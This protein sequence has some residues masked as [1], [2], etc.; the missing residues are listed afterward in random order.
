MSPSAATPSQAHQPVLLKETLAAIV[1]RNGGKYVD[2]TLG[3]GGHTEA[4]LEASAPQGRVLGMDVDPQALEISSER[5]QK[6]DGR[7][8]IVHNSYTQLLE[9][10]HRIGWREVDGVLFDLGVS[11][12]QLDTSRRGFSFKTDAPL[13]MRFD[14]ANSISAD[15]LVNTLPEEDL[16]NLIWKFGEERESRRIAR[17]VC[18]ARPVHTTG[19]LA[20]IIHRAIRKSSGRIDPATR[21]FQA[22]RIAVNSELQAIE[23]ALPCAVEA[24]KPGGRLAVISFHSLEDRLVKQFMRRE[25]SDCI[26]PPGTPVCTCGHKA[27]L[28]ELSRKGITVSAFETDQNPRARSA[29]LRTAEKVGLA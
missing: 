16:A 9:E 4:M 14:P 20:E 7:V 19:Q 3:A 29:R 10:M 23:E 13:D 1:P 6:F 25:S 26:C 24:L 18:A 15:T 21:T 27:S 2:A 5:L 28:R 17:A 12:M 22:L 8:T 11:S